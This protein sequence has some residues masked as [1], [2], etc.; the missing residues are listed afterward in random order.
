MWFHLPKL[1]LHCWG[2]ESLSRIVNAIGVPLFA[3][4]C[5]SKKLCVSYARVLVE[6]DIT[7]PLVKQVRIRDNYGKE[8]AQLTIPEW[9]PY[10]CPKCHK[11]GHVCTEKNHPKPTTTRSESERTE[12]VQG[13]TS[14]T[15]QQHTPSTSDCHSTQPAD[16]N[17][18]V[19]QKHNNEGE[20]AIVKGSRT[21]TRHN[22]NSV[23]IIPVHNNNITILSEVNE[24]ENST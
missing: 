9:Y 2:E 19:D 8:F 6:V 3:D 22:N 24:Q 11:V 16:P 12:R 15:E 23:N 20:W 10:Y 14:S 18:K 7:N 17:R 4:D 21:A 5:T 1:P 13:Q